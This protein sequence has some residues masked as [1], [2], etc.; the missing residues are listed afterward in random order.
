MAEAPAN[1]TAE[2]RTETGEL[3][4]Q[5][6]TETTTTPSTEATSDDQSK[7]T[8]STTTPS[9]DKSLMSESK[10]KTEGA[11]ETYADFKAPDGYEFN[12]ERM[13]EASALFKEANLS[14]D[15]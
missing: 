7:T 5:T 3:K 14:Q 10:E 6:S 11:P 2:A 1:N 4:A 9:T 15:Q 12:K 13:G 8:S